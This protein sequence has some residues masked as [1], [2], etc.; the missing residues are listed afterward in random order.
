[1]P[2]LRVRVLEAGLELRNQLVDE[3]EDAPNGSAAEDSYGVNLWPAAQI[4]AQAVV[5]WANAHPRGGRGG[6]TSPPLRV[7][8]LGAGV[9]LCAL[10]A[11]SIGLEA[12]ATDYRGVTLALVRA[13]AKRQGLEV[14]LQILDMRDHAGSPLPEADLVVVADVLAFPTVAEALAF[15][16]AEA[17]ARFGASVLVADTGRGFR[18][19]FL[20]KLRELLPQEDESVFRFTSGRGIAIQGDRKE[21][22]L[23][24]EQ[25]LSLIPDRGEQDAEAEVGITDT[26]SSRGVFRD[27][28]VDFGV[29]LFELP[30]PTVPSGALVGGQPTIAFLP[31]GRRP[32]G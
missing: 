32:H 31:P 11:A 14:G 8:E 22:E 28:I 20:D 6:G 27:S 9:G 7:L 16:V 12:L 3:A 1:M 15:R 19:D 2:G 10:T 21:M 24:I 30:N 5:A 17:R 26:S 23:R 18:Q 4:A 25:N 13:A 29:D